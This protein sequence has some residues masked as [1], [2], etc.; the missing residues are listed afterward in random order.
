MRPLLVVRAA[1]VVLAAALAA[2]GVA[3]AFIGSDDGT[4][5]AFF[6]A[7]LAFWGLGVAAGTFGRRAGRPA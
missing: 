7:G 3:G 1:C 2:V 4:A 5:W 6:L